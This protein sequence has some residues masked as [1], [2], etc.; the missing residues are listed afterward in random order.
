MVDVRALGLLLS[1]VLLGGCSGS[2]PPTPKAV[3][4][5]VR[6]PS[7][8]ASPP[9]SPAAVVVERGSGAFST[10][11]GGSSTTGAGPLLTY[12]VEL[13]AGLGL[14]PVGVARSV[15]TTLADPRSWTS[16][17]RRS[18][19]RVAGEADLRVSLASPATVDRLCAPLRTLGRYSCANGD[20]VVLNVARWLTGVP[21]YEGR[22]EEYRDY[23]V[24]H[25]VGHVLGFGH[26]PC[27]GAGQVAPVMLQQSIGLDGCTRGPW[28]YP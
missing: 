28:P 16:G 19:R 20:R 21:A 27:P 24:N 1:A 22:L 17:G 7:P 8:P 15:D 2:E 10:V 23:L 4:A 9:P 14:D 18:L 26:A 3:A 11:P 12:R 13:E 5:A 6:S 25:E